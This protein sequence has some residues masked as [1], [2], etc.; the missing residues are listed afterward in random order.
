M[1][2]FPAPAKINLHLLVT[3]T[4]ENGYHELDTSFAYVDVEDELQISPSEKLIVTCSNP[5]FNGAHNLVYQVLDAFRKRYGITSGLE[6]HINKHLP[7]QAGLGGGSSDAATAL[8]VAND[9]WELNL[10]VGDLIAFAAPFGADIPCFLFGKASLARGIGEQLT[11]Y[12]DPLPEGTLLLAYPGIGLSTPAVF[13]C[14]DSRIGNAGALTHPD[15][16]DT[17][18]GLSGRA[19]G[20]NDLESCACSISSEV[21][22]LLEQMRSVSEHAWMSG[23]GSTCVALF[24]DQKQAEN[25]ART[26]V[27]HKLATWTHIGKLLREHPLQREKIGA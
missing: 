26:L 8:M 1:N 19:I 24:T 10:P 6:I 20:N 7:D 18:R 15:S 21:V 17:I 14:Y 25:A 2:R 12:P 16:A 9:H 4:L 5:A 13:Q 27:E 23:S 3:R 22:K 11:D